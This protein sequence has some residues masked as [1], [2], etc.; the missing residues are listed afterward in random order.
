MRLQRKS[1]PIG[2]VDVTAFSDLAFLLIVFFV[3][4][5]TFVRPFGAALTIPSSTSDPERKQ[6]EEFPTINIGAEQL[7][8][9]EQE[10]T[11][12]ALR[13]ALLEMELGKKA[14][15]K[16]FVV[17]DTAP[18]VGF[19]RYYRVVTAIARAGGILAIVEQVEEGEQ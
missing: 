17:V 8:L 6:E 2:D 16:R 4:T 10:M 12:E 19:Q 7:L 11:M 15:D 1:K 18:D 5:T 9:N 13:D 14:D 3:L